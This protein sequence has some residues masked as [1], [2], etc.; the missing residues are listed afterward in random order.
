MTTDPSWL[1]STIAQSSAAIV[2]IIGGFITA[3][4]LNLSAE[5]RSLKRQWDINRMQ[6]K[7]LENS[8][9]NTQDSEID[10]SLVVT[11]AAQARFEYEL[12]RAPRFIWFGIGILAYLSVI[13]IL[14][15]VIAIAYEVFNVTLKFWIVMLFSLGIIGLFIYM[16]LLIKSIRRK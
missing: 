15:P 1:Y 16:I 11:K 7:T 6:M 5:S 9:L 13:G 3:T 8:N 12:L 4:A 10:K 2:A 14:I